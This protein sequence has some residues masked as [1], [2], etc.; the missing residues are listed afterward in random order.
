MLVALYFISM[1]HLDKSYSV[2]MLFVSVVV[3]VS[4]CSEAEVVLLHFCSVNVVLKG[5]HTYVVTSAKHY[6]S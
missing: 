4:C 3:S 6:K 1:W 5:C 2:F